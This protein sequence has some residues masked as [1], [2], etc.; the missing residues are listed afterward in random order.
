MLTRRCC[1]AGS[2]A[3]LFGLAG[4]K[5]A[6]ARHDPVYGC[7]LTTNEANTILGDQQDAPLT[8]DRPMIP[9]SDDKDFDFALAQTLSMISDCLNV[10]PNFAYYDDYDGPNALASRRKHVAGTDG[11]VLFGQRLLKKLMA[12]P[13]A[14]DAA[15]AGV[16]AHEFGH[17]LQYKLDLDTDLRQGQPTVKRVELHADFFAGYFAG[18]RKRQTPSFN[19]AAIALA[20]FNSGDN[21]LNHPT[22]HGTHEERGKAI[23]KGFETGYDDRKPLLDAI[24]ISLKYVT[25]NF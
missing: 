19:A 15:V 1:L 17:I 13:E 5:A 6:A 3:L 24:Q 10:T 2:G 18:V 23:V 12:N 7:S 9:H 4:V 20:Q 16:C 22:H 25:A 21:M 14:R 8:D 11:T